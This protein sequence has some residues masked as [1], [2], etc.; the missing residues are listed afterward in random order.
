MEYHDYCGVNCDDKC[1][2]VLLS[3]N[4][5]MYIEAVYAH[6]GFHLG[7]LLGGKCDIYQVEG[8]EVY[9]NTCSL[10]ALNRIF[11]SNVYVY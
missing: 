5:Y 6:V 7:F 11:M 1:D 8:G 9:S 3:P 10:S 4:H 2:G